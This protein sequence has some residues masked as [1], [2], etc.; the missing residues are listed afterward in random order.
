MQGCT[1]LASLDQQISVT[2]ILPGKFRY[3]PGMQPFQVLPHA[4]RELFM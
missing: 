2:E 4:V 3:V 1:A